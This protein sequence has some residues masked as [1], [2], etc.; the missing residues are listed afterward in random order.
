MSEVSDCILQFSVILEFHP[1]AFKNSDGSTCSANYQAVRSL[2]AKNKLIAYN[3][4]QECNVANIACFQQVSMMASRVRKPEKSTSVFQFGLTLVSCMA[5]HSNLPEY[6]NSY[7]TA[8][9]FKPVCDDDGNWM[10]KQCKGGLQG[11]AA[12]KRGSRKELAGAALFFIT[13]V[14]NIR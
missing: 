3:S 14:R 5:Y 12:I 2:F 8:Q 11:S 13:C 1:L 7:W 9:K 6:V 4:V 10:P